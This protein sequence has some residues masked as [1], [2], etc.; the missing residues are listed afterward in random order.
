MASGLNTEKKPNTCDELKIVASSNRIKF[1]SAPPPRTLN[2]DAPSPALVTPGSNKIDFKTSTS[3][4]TTGILLIAEIES[5]LTLISGFR[6]S[7]FVLVSVTI[8]SFN[9]FSEVN[10][11]KFVLVFFSKSIFSSRELYPI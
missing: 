3:P 5:L 9:V 1:W 10:S 7:V 6:I 4:K 2:P 11:L 8:T